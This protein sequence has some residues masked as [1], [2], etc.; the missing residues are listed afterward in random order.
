MNPT[1]LTYLLFLFSSVAFLCNAQKTEDFTEEVA[2]IAQRTDSI[3]DE[4]KETIVFTGSS[5]V[6]LWEGLEELFPDHQILN[7]GFGGSQTRDLFEHL[8]PLV[9]S[10][11]PK[12][13]FIYE[14]DND[15]N[16]RKRPKRVIRITKKIIDTIWQ[17]YPETEVVLISS[18][19]SIVRWHLKK[20]YIKLNLKLKEF[21]ER[22]PRVAFA[23]VWDI[24]LMNEVINESLFI[25]DGL[26]MNQKGYDLWYEVIK[27]F[28]N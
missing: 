23:N 2:M 18:K 1:K 16:F 15:I 7:T 27:S 22:T 10:Y 21:A 11:K 17:H 24:M 20:R 19:P 6:R 12:M 26:H 3:W 8:Q 28:L 4:N 5:S 13:V 14:G 9:L 25:E